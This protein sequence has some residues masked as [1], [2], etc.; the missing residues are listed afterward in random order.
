MMLWMEA[1]NIDIYH[2]MFVRHRIDGSDLKD[3]NCEKLQVLNF[4]INHHHTHTY[5]CT[6]ICKHTQIPHHTYTSYRVLQIVRG[7]KV[8]W[9]SRINW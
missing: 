6:C 8:S 5:T 9:F 1:C 3:L 7:G 2:G 4:S